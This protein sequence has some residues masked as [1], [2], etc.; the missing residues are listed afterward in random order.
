[1]TKV[2]LIAPYG[3]DVGGIA[4]WT[5]HILSYHKDLSYSNIEIELFSIGR[6][7]VGKLIERKFLRIYN[8]ILVYLSVFRRFYCVLK[9]KQFDVLHITSS[10]SY[11][12]FRDYLMIKLGNRYGAKCIIHFRF[13]RI[14]EL[15]R[16]KNWEWKILKKVIKISDKAIVLDEKSFQSLVA[17][18]MTNVTKLPN[19]VSPKVLHLVQNFSITERHKREI[20]FV[21]HCYR[22]KGI[23]EAIQACNRI[24]NVKLI[25]LGSITDEIK[26]EIQSITKGANWIEIRGTTFYED[27][28][29]Q[30]LVCSVLILPSYSEGFPNVILEAMVCGCP[31]VAT[32]VGAIP[33]MLEEDGKNYGLLIRPK[34]VDGLKLA[35]E[36]MLSD[37]LF[38]K[39]CSKNVRERV[40]T[41]YGMQKIWEKLVEIWK[42]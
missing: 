33:E 16:Q 28:I 15:A 14:P 23:I 29:K 8:G 41:R 13:G 40:L 5:E 20:L 19:P 34:D 38:Q 4:R 30:M 36:R 11:G 18:G 6:T 2:L 17:E 21:G 22:A 35:I 3:K 39:E 37:D 27:V 1:M 24:E 7:N 10:A 25:L 9:T 31:I 32:D 26:N 42:N 12:L